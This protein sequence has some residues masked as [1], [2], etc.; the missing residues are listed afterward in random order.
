MSKVEFDVIMSD[1]D[2]EFSSLPESIQVKIEKFDE[3]FESYQEIE[4][5]ETAESDLMEKMKALDKGISADLKQFIATQKKEKQEEE[6]KTEPQNTQQQQ[7][8]QSATTP[9]PTTESSKPS[10]AFWM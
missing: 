8:T 7:P 4:D 9:N 3:I 6:V 1:N 10:W 2:L 5:D